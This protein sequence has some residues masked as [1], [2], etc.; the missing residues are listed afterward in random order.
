MTPYHSHKF[1]VNRSLFGAIMLVLIGLLAA[2]QSAPGIPTPDTPTPTL[3][4]AETPAPETPTPAPDAPITLTLWLPTLFLPQQ[5]NTAY[6]MMQ[7]QLAAFSRSDD[8]VPTHTEVKQD[9]GPGGLLDLLRTASPVA[10]SILPDIIALDSSDLETAARAGLIQPIDTLVPADLINDHFPFAHDLVTINGE[11]FGLIYSADLEHLITVG[12]DTPPANWIDLLNAKQ[13]YVFAPHDGSKNVSDAVLV[14]YLSSAGTLVD[15]LGNPLI[16]PAVL[17]SLLED[18]QTAQQ[19]GDLPANFLDLSSPDDA[20]TTWRATRNGYGQIQ[21]TRYL[22]VAA[23]LPD[24]QVAAL[25]GLLR[26]AP[27]IGRGWALAIV[28]RDPRRQAAASRL[29]Q[30]LLSPQNNGEWTQAAGVLPGRQGA[31]TTWD[32]SRPYTSFIRDQLLQARAAPPNAVANVIQPALREAVD[33]VLA[34]R[35]TPAEAAQ[36]AAAAVNGGKK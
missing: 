11:T 3:A 9:R 20:W 35:A 10:P 7:H 28:T 33:D 12:S 23:Q 8:G 32:Q 1:H 18:Y 13:R 34:G 24:A 4:P 22:S 6:N 27:P 30:Q 14:H 19:Q 15:D 2:C 16:K 17:E 25:P 26:L 31:L 36:A 29:L 21:A 5:G